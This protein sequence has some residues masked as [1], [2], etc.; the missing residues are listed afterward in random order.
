MKILFNKQLVT[1]NW[2][3]LSVVCCLLTIVLF[4][5]CSVS[6]SGFTPSKKYSPEQLTKDYS[7]FRGA[8][9]ESHPGVYW[10]TSK[11]EMDNYFNWGKQQIKDSLNEEDFRKV[12]SYV[13]SKINC[14]HTVTRASKAFLKFRD[15]SFNKIFPLSLKIWP[16]VNSSATDT[17]TIAANLI[18]KDSTLTRGIVVKQID[19][20]PISTILDTLCQ[21]ISSDGYNLTHKYQSLSNRGGFGAAFTSIFGPKENYFIDYLDT[22]GRERTATIPSYNPRADSV[23]RVAISRFARTNRSERRK[24]IIMATRNLRF[25]TV[26][27]VAFMDLGSFG[28]NLQLKSFFRNSFKEM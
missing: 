18:R 10:Y 5:S 27:Q 7:I 8:L 17:A 20:R 26:N 24:Q 23:N 22:D 13:I 16:A 4:S 21:Y 19:H 11:D 25:D 28:R 12:L 14:G 3:Y 6:K 9:E 2:R 1:G 15:T